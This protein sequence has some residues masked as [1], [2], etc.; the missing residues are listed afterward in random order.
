MLLVT[1]QRLKAGLLPLRVLNRDDLVARLFNGCRKFAISG[2]R[3]VKKG[4]ALA[5]VRVHFGSAGT[6]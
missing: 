3:D 1:Y 5:P 6:C 4:S 2:R